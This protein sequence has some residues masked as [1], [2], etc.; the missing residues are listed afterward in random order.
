MA[1]VS[2]SLGVS[3]VEGAQDPPMT[4]PQERRSRT[5]PGGLDRRRVGG[6]VAYEGVERRVA[7][8]D[9]GL[10]GAVGALNT[11]SSSVPTGVESEQRGAEAVRRQG[12]RRPIS[13]AQLLIISDAT[14][15]AGISAL[16][17]G[18]NCYP[19]IATVATLVLL[20]AFGLYRPRLTR[21]ALD[22]LPRILGASLAGTVV[23]AS[24]WNLPTE[25][26]LGAR[27]VVVG[28]CAAA[29]LVIERTLVYAVIG[30]W[31]RKR[32]ARPTLIIGAG[33]VAARL[34]RS[35]STHPA[36]GLKL[37]GYLDDDPMLALEELGAPVLGNVSS[38]TNT[39]LDRGVTDVFV[40]F[41]TMSSASMVDVLRTCDRLSCEIF[42]VP[43]LFEL[44]AMTRDTD[45][46]DGLPVVR[47]RRATYR[48]RTW[49]LKRVLDLVAASSAMLL[50]SP[51]LLACA[52]AVRREGGPGIFFRQ[53]RVGL[54]GREF[55]IIKFRSM[56][57]ATAAESQT[58][59]N[60]SHDGRIGPVGRFLRRTS[61]DEL[62]QLFN[63][64]RGDMSMVGP[65]P[66][67]P[68]F[69]EQ[70]RAAYPSYTARSRVP[71]GLTGLAAVN[72]L[73]GDTS[74]EERARYDN[75]YIENWSLWL[76]VTIML[77]TALAVVRRTGG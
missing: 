31:R 29:I 25:A 69:V 44:H 33:L 35:I 43:R 12:T 63:V 75:V 7:D 13:G 47:A 16:S 23:I 24:F 18:L 65:R 64:L 45:Q 34:G 36:L 19:L 53:R 41:G 70:F 17:Q 71:A 74:I 72:G 68:H 6:G 54:D 56:R 39:I 27:A 66:E 77:R 9:E 22:D 46:V 21:S 49:A 55:E 3:K 59:W 2:D 11:T 73:R 28:L 37:V 61:L 51:L 60:V 32:I 15:I 52:V 30:A 50:V 1:A 8:H 5:G 26:P 57:P 76:D 62:P 58:L 14:G 20:A 42:F 4:P 38:L 40:A 67:R 10:V 48:S